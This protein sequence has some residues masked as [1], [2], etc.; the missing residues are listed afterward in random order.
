M[1][2]TQLRNTIAKIDKLRQE[3]RAASRLTSYWS[4]GDDGFNFEK[5]IVIKRVWRASKRERAIYELSGEEASLLC[6]W[7]TKR[8]D[9]LIAEADELSKTL[10][11]K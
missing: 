6:E 11:A 10:A 5:D 1:N 7:L 8:S 2:E 9:E 3:A 4:G